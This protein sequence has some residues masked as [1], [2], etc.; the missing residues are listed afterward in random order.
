MYNIYILKSQIDDTYYIG[1]TDNLER[2]V[3]EHNFG[4]KGYT[5]KKRPWKL[6]YSEECDNKTE[7][8]KREIYLKRNKSRV[9][10]EELIKSGP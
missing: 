7:A 6:V 9:Y 1:Y 4:K 5:R 8:I 3:Y 10:I 2:R